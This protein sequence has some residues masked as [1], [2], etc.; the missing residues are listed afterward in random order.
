MPGSFF[1][2][3]ILIYGASE[4][5]AKADRTLGLIV[6]GGSISVQVLNEFANVARR[7]M[8]LTWSETR[9]AIESV[10]GLLHVHPLTE[11]IHASGLGLAERYGLSIYDA[12]IV[13]SALEADCDV[14]WSEDLHHGLEVG[15]VLRVVNP[16]LTA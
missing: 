7:K 14:L 10:R 15:G 11:H 1:D 9:S 2:T 5:T 3:N 6:G 13:A 16:F 4:D 12:M 8:G